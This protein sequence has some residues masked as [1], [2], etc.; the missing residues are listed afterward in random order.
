M[1]SAVGG[2]IRVGDEARLEV[3]TAGCG[4]RGERILA[5]VVGQGPC[6]L[7]GVQ[8]REGELDLV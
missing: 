6:H 7:L 1:A 8:A 3:G 4:S 2:Q 5:E